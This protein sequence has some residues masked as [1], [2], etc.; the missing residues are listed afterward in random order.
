M[1][2]AGL[3]SSSL[4]LL[5]HCIALMLLVMWRLGLG[6]LLALLALGCTNSS[7][8]PEHAHTHI[9][10][11]THTRAVRGVLQVLCSAEG[12]KS[13]E[14]GGGGVSGEEGEGRAR[15][16]T[17]TGALCSPQS[18]ILILGCGYSG[19]RL[20]ASVLSA[21]GVLIGHER[22]SPCGMSNWMATYEESIVS[23][24]RN[25]FLQV[26]HP[27]SVLNSALS[28]RW[29]FDAHWFYKINTMPA[30]D[31]GLLP[32]QNILFEVNVSAVIMQ[33]YPTFHWDRLTYQFKILAW[34]VAYNERALT[35][36]TNWYRLEDFVDPHCA[37]NVLKNILYSA[38]LTYQSLWSNDSSTSEVNM[39]HS[40][41]N[42]HT[43]SKKP[44][45]PKSLW[46]SLL[47]DASSRNESS[48]L[49]VLGHAKQLAEAFGYKIDQK[50][51]TKNMK[52]QMYQNKMLKKERM[53]HKKYKSERSRVKSILK[54]ELSRDRTRHSYNSHTGRR[55]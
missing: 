5:L 55:G 49:I 35:H 47:R 41:V 21:H 9:H 7:V 14:G 33:N 32:A 27:L 22:I 19:T 18:K 42:S 44:T 10:P 46:R 26:R 52:E 43:K 25:V 30:V 23:A 2:L 13:A 17:G 39:L 29:K 40:K 53:N 54:F 50:V 31:I 15:G 12:T 45:E 28:S 24:F 4:L 20:I 8:A 3:A 36:A 6:L 48:E 38:N 51:R 37:A 11:H 1:E 16:G 34:W